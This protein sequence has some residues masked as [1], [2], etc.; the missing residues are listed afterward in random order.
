MFV[1][2]EEA[3][4]Y[5]RVEYSEDDGLIT[6]LIRAAEEDVKSFINEPDLRVVKNPEMIK[7]GIKLLTNLWFENRSPVSVGN[8]IPREM[9][10]MVRR[11]LW[12]ERNVAL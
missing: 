4:A 12:R 5:M 1:T 10:L 7:L 11:L 9:P 6:S 3:K 2:L 8:T